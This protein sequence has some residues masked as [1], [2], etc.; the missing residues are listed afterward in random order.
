MKPVFEKVPRRQWESFH[1]EVIRGPDYGTRWHFH[2]EYQITLAVRSEGHRVVGDHIAP[3]S[4]GDMVLLGA[5]VPHVWRQDERGGGNPRAV[6][7]IVVRFLDS[8]LGDEFLAKPEMEGVRHLLRRSSRG[9]QVTGRA[10]DDVAARFA[11]LPALAGLA[12]VVALLDILDVLA[13]SRELRPLASARY[14]PVLRHEDQDRMERVCDHIHKHLTDEIERGDLARVAHLSE[15]AFSRFF[16]SR[17]GKTVPEY[18]NELRV[19]RACHMLAEERLN[20]TDIALDCGFRNLANFNRRFREIVK[21]TPR[22]YRRR[23]VA[24]RRRE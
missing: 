18:V 22:D 15:G 7:A 9:L 1:C 3:L 5:N 17:T 11:R 14:A 19:G 16:R 23:A 10:R 13:R 24:L 12:R 2:P 8:F 20:I 6:E 21:M 4:D